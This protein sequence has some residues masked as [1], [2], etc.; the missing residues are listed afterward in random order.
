[1]RNNIKHALV[2]LVAAA[3]LLAFS[4]CADDDF[5]VDD[6]QT[7]ITITGLTDYDGKYATGGLGQ[8]DADKNDPKVAISYPTKI[9]NGKVSVEMWKEKNKG[10]GYEIASVSAPALVILFIGENAQG[11]DYTKK[12][13]ISAPKSVGPGSPPKNTFDFKDFEEF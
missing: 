11:K 3:I 1:M 9:N 5:F 10:N 2:A 4:A 8:V 12:F 7:I 6:E 13:Y